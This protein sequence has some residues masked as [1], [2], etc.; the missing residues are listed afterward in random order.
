VDQIYAS[1]LSGYGVTP[2]KPARTAFQAAALPAGALLMLDVIAA[3]P[4]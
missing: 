2:A 1:W 3:C 4:D